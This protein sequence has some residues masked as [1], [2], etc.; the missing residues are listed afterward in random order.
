MD[1]IPQNQVDELNVRSKIK[2][3]NSLLEAKRYKLYNFGWKTKILFLINRVISIFRTYASIQKQIHELATS[4]ND[5]DYV[6]NL[7]FYPKPLQTPVKYFDE[8][9]DVDFEG[10]KLKSIKEYDAY[11]RQ[12]YGDYMQLPPLEQQVPRHGF[13]AYWK[14]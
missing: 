8:Y 13:T 5:G 10:Y 11:L 1:Y 7:V 2:F 4:F 9:I 6:D 3:L 14:A 12:I